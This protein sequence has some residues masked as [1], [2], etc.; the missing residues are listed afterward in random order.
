MSK[1]KRTNLAD[2]KALGPGF[3]NPHEFSTFGAQKESAFKKKI[4]FGNQESRKFT[5]QRN[6][7]SPFTDS[8][9]VENPDSW[10]YQHPDKESVFYQKNKLKSTMFNDKQQYPLGLSTVTK[11]V[12]KNHQSPGPGSYDIN[13]K[14]ELKILD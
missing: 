5:L 6:M 1:T 8:T 13:F 2:E 11:A 9:I 10:K 3:Y 7:Q 4:D 12:H 14:D